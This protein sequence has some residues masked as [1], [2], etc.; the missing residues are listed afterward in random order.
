MSACVNL[1]WLQGHTA[2]IAALPA[3]SDANWEAQVYTDTRSGE[4]L[5]HITAYVERALL[6]LSDLANEP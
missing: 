5:D 3:D 6:K 2:H 4:V 1:R